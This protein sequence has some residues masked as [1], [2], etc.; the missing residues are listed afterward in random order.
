MKWSSCEATEVEPN[1]GIGNPTQFAYGQTHRGALT[2]TDVK[3]YYRITTAAGYAQEV[4]ITVNAGMTMEVS[5]LDVNENAVLYNTFAT[6]GYYYTAPSGTTFSPNLTNPYPMA[7][8]EANKQQ[9]VFHVKLLPSTAYYIVVQRPGGATASTTWNVGGTLDKGVYDITVAADKTV[10]SMVAAVYDNWAETTGSTTDWYQ[11]V[12]RFT[13]PGN[14]DVATWDVVNANTGAVLVPYVDYFIHGIS[15]N[16]GQGGWVQTS[17]IENQLIVQPTDVWS[18]IVIHFTH[19]SSGDQYYFRFTTYDNVKGRYHRHASFNVNLGGTTTVTQVNMP[20]NAINVGTPY[21]VTADLAAGS[22][23]GRT[24][25]WWIV[26][27]SMPT[28]TM[29]I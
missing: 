19:A 10:Q 27:T 6:D 26:D 3:D 9:G 5:I 16:N 18:A 2:L 12:A 17:G 4:D 29:P 1:D 25:L 24:Y 7:G 23:S 15:T 28:G 22:I 21:T 20:L 11:A 13:A 14:Y 8:T